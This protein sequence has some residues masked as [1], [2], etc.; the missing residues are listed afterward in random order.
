[1]GDEVANLKDRLAEEIKQALKA[2]Q[3]VRLAALRLLSSSVHNREVE[4]RRPLTEE[5]FR[6]V[7]A[8]EVRRRGESIEAYERG[9]R[10]ELVAREREEREVLSAYLPP[11]LSDEEIDALVTEAIAATGATSEMEMGKVM[12]NVMARAKGKVDGKA[13]RARVRTRLGGRGQATP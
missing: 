5:E 10:P 8:R 12:G 7:V 4:V 2:G 3:K 13:V 9:G 6:E 1:V 11:Q